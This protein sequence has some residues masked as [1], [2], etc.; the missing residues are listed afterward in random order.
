M[1]QRELRTGDTVLYDLADDP[2]EKKNLWADKPAGAPV[3]RLLDLLSLSA[4]GNLKQLY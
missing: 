4:T 1:L 3:A 2:A